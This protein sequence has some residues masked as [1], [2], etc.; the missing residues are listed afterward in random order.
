MQKITLQYS[1]LYAPNLLTYS[2]IKP[3]QIREMI[4]K[5][6]YLIQFYGNCMWKVIAGDIQVHKA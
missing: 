4:N 5:T 2:F 6:A 1:S 3:L